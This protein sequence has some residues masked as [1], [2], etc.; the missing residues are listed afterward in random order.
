MKKRI[1]KTK[2]QTDFQE[3]MKEYVGEKWV[4]FNKSKENRQLV[5]DDFDKIKEHF[6]DHPNIIEYFENIKQAF[7]KAEVEKWENQ[8]KLNKTATAV[9]AFIC[10]ADALSRELLK[11]AMLK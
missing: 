8:L 7:L 2:N 10:M 4:T 5:L 11:S 1:K 3:T 9:T 6:T